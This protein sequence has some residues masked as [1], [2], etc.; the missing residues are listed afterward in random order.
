M[1]DPPPIVATR[2]DGD[3][4]RKVARNGATR[5]KASASRNQ[6]RDQR[7]SRGAGGAVW[8]ALVVAI[9]VAAGA[10]AWGYL[11]HQQLTGLQAE[12]ASSNARIADL[13]GIM[14]STGESMNESDVAIRAKIKELYSEVDKL[15]ASAWRR[16]KAKIAEH[17]KSLASLQQIGAT[18]K[19]STTKLRADLTLIENQLGEARQMSILLE[20]IRTQQGLQEAVIS[21]LSRE[22]DNVES[23]QKGLVSRVADNEEWVQSNLEFRKQVS[24]RLSQLENPGLPPQ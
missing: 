13:E 21:R 3:S 12:L 24:R 16:N 10:L 14:T 4:R 8:L 19:T 22:T 5:A 23:V 6:T 18:N 17:E 11:L 20:E 7:Q 2:D 1:S 9:V 15:W